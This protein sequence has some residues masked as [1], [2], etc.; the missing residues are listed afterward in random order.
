MNDLR[1][2]ER[3]R[4][5]Q[6]IRELSRW[7]APGLGIKRWFFLVLAGIT[8]LG[9]G[10][11]IL[12]LN[13]YRTEFTNQIV[14]NILSYASLRFLPRVLRFLIFSALGMGLVAYGMY[15]L[16]HSLLRP[17]I[18][19]GHAVVDELANYRRRERGRPLPTPA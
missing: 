7:L 14:L 16:N 19:P 13:L 18:R 3:E 6:N 12:L 4:F 17:F 15:R 2:A 9:V 10:L 5:K 8:F 1:K 11:A